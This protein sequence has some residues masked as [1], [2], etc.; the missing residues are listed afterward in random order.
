[1]YKSEIC[2][3]RRQLL[4]YWFVMRAVNLEP[5][6]NCEIRSEIGDRLRILLSREEPAVP[7]RLRQLVRRL[8]DVEH[9]SGSEVSPTAPETSHDDAARS[10]VEPIT[11]RLLKFIRRTR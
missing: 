9:G 2:W 10:E 1:M 6:H 5:K 11:A 3:E 8:D 4:S 7:A